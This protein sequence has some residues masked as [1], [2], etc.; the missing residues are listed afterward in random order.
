[1]MLF[2]GDE[3]GKGRVLGIVAGGCR[4]RTDRP[5]LPLGPDPTRQVIRG[6]TV[7]LK[8]LILSANIAGGV[9]TAG[10]LA[11]PYRVTLNIV[12]RFISKKNI[13]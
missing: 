2:I 13:L 4:V 10:L 12:G 6:R 8:G 3:G 9:G 1:M 11:G 7:V 5:C